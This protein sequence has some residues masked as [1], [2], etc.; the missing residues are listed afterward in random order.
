M[1]AHRSQQ[2]TVRGHAERGPFKLDVRALLV[3]LA[4]LLGILATL[5]YFGR[6][7][8]TPRRR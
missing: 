5:L 1:S 3:I 2:R 8:T 7:T 4:V 6:D